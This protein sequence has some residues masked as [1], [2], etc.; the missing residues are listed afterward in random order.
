M[1][2]NL[3]IYTANKHGEHG[4]DFIIKHGGQIYGF[5][6]KRMDQLGTSPS[7]NLMDR[8]ELG[9]GA[10]WSNVQQKKSIEMRN[11]SW[12][13]SQKQNPLVN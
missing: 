3:F 7:Q 6:L 5:A 13:R 2:P 10:G 1:M 4:W 9:P 12:Q 11:T 8:M